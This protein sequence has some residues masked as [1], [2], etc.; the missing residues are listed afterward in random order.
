MQDSIVSLVQQV[1]ACMHAGKA[2]TL[3]CRLS[4]T[5]ALSPMQNQLQS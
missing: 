4:V 2:I 5:P 1:T 3:S